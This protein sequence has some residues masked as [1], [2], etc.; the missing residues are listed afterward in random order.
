MI[1]ITGNSDCGISGGKSLTPTIRFLLFLLAKRASA[2]VKKIVTKKAAP[3]KVV[4]STKKAAP[5][6]AVKKVVA[7]K[8]AAKK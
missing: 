7:K 1:L 8:A 2:P 3:K 5:K 4:K 6:K